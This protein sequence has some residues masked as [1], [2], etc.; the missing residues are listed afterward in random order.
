MARTN[1]L[2]LQWA[3]G[4]ESVSKSVAL[5]NEGVIQV[6]AAVGAG[7]SNKQVAAAFDKD[8]LSQVYIVS[9][10]D[11]TM[12]TNDG[13]TPDDS[14]SLSANKPFVW[15]AGCGIPNP[16][17]ADV[18]ALFFSNAGASEATVQIRV[19]VDATP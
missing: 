8:T 7:V 11:V 1:T 15:Y 2:T 16:F 6:D 18:T 10:Q 14:F 17:S 4:S 19:L 3:Q 5:S 12:E 9:D 13:T